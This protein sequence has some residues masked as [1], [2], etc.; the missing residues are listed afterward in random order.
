MHPSS[1]FL[2]SFA[3]VLCVAAAT[4]V[5]CQRLKLPVVMGY[6]AAGVL[7]GPHAPPLLVADKDTITTL[8]EMGIILLMFSIGMELSVRKLVEVGP[9]SGAVCL[10]EMGLMAILGYLVARLLGFPPIECAFVAAMV[11]ISSTT[12][13][14]RTFDEHR[15]RQKLRE[16]V[17]SA[18]VMEDVVAVLL[19]AVLTTLAM[20]QSF[21]IA[22]LAAAAGRLTVFLMVLMVVGVLVVPRLI[23]SVV[24]LNRPET[25]LV[26][27]VG[28]CFAAALAAQRYEYSVALGAFLAG[29]LVAESGEGHRIGIQIRPLRDIFT[30]VFFVSVGLSIDPM[31]L[32]AEWR[33]IALFSVIVVVGKFVGVT[34]GF[35]LVGNSIRQ[36]TQAGAAMGQIGEFSFIIVGLG[37]AL[38]AI[39]SRWLPVAVGVSCLTIMLTPFAVSRSA[40]F[41]EWI[42]ARLPRPLQTFASLYGTWVE[43]LGRAQTATHVRAKAMRL[44]RLIVIDAALLVGILITGAVGSDELATY[45]KK[46]L[47]A[48]AD[49]MRWLV[50]AGFVILAAPLALGLFRLIRALGR[51][52]AISALPPAPDGGVDFAQA[53]RRTFVVTLQ[54]GITAIVLLPCVAITQ[55]F[56]PGIKGALP[57]PLILGIAA[58]AFWRSATQLQGHVRAGAQ[59]LAEAVAVS[60]RGPGESMDEMEQ[61]LPGLGQLASHRI[62]PDSA[63]CRRSLGELN[64]RATTGAS[65]LAIRRGEDA[66][67]TPDGRELLKPGDVLVLAGTDEALTAAR[68]A[69]N[70]GARFE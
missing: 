21:D 17:F 69:L 12:I 30:A 44:V 62:E 68:Q 14:A 61:L 25:T 5:A 65:I 54:L 67:L 22:A 43:Q 33:L 16:G 19:I 31:Q 58:F 15:V 40:R 3:I 28:V 27:A 10:I 34:L 49:F 36:A 55:P 4:T 9:K 13:I 35:F 18:L 57:L 59:A 39:D 46:S 41:G 42:E 1:P 29:C 45:L 6:L 24:A 70:S 23:R 38:N 7:I 50:V 52:L 51:E 48:A 56:I 47:P 11:S 64:L 8:S 2:E 60:A 53:P 37:V 20:T 66:V 26:T 32:L 63:W